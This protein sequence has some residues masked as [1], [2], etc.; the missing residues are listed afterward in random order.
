MRIL[1]QSGAEIVDPDLENGRLV[2]D[3]IVI[4]HHDVVPATP[5]QIERKLV[6]EK[7]GSALYKKVVVQPYSPAKPAW[8]EVE[9]IKRYVPYTADELEQIE[10]EKAALE[11]ERAAA[12]AAEA[13]QREREAFADAAPDALIELSER[14]DSII[15]ALAESDPTNYAH[16]KEDQDG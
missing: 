1:D 3:E 14:I 2:D 13:L 6:S 15:D 4:A 11:D 7:D 12:E 5:R 10:L 9:A 16:L 8:D